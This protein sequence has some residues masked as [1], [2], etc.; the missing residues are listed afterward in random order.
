[1][2][3]A[4]QTIDPILIT[5]DFSDQPI[6]FDATDVSFRIV[7]QG[8]LGADEAIV[9]SKKEFI[10]GK[11]KISSPMEDVYSIVDHSQVKEI[12]QGFTT[13]KMKLKNTTPDV[14]GVSQDMDGNLVLIAK[15]QR[16]PCYTPDLTGNN[17]FLCDKSISEEFVSI[18]K[19]Q[20]LSL[21]AGKTDTF[22]FDFSEQLIPI[23]AFELL[24]QI[25]YQGKIGNGETVVIATKNMEAPS[26]LNIINSTDYIELNRSYYHVETE[27]YPNP[28]LMELTKNHD[29]APYPLA[30]I[31]V[32]QRWNGTI[33]LEMDK[34]DVT[35]YFRAAALVDDDGASLRFSSRINNIFG[36]L[37]TTYLEL[38]QFTYYKR[39]LFGYTKLT[40]TRGVYANS[41]IQSVGTLYDQPSSLPRNLK[42][43]PNE[44]LEPKSVTILFGA[45][46]GN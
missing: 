23:N 29:I 12:D 31:E 41:T 46:D 30:E 3:L 45:E 25:V 36:Q 13:I 7:Y 15:Y 20:T 10:G 1:M 14:D 9:V 43:L 18:S 5:F 16:N 32:S 6:P 2:S 42:D 19:E 33:L 11:L 24:F 8:Q 21:E 17:P 22:S 4:A 37:L 39:W 38:N 28:D 26:Y 27:V 35:T 44:N 40:N 34:L